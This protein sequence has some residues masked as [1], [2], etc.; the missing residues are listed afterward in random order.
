MKQTLNVLDVAKICHET[1]RAYCNALGDSSQSPWAE[2]PDWQK[3]S[4]VNGVNFHLEVPV[5][6]PADS[7]DNWL[8]EKIE[9][10]WKYGPMKDPAKKE[11]PCCVPFHEL[12]VEQR[13]KDYLFTTIVRTLAPMVKR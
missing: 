12:P 10:G 13:M 7:H 2:A 6:G 1:N 11:H 4:A 5:R 8:K 3:E 9:N